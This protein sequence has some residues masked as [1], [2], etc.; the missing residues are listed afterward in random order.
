MNAAASF[1]YFFVY[2]RFNTIKALF[3]VSS[4]F[5]VFVRLTINNEI[6]IVPHRTKMTVTTLPIMVLGKKSPNPTLI[7]VETEN[8]NESSKVLIIGGYFPSAKCL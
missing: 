2:N 3:S 7:I 6:I 8:Q 4:I 5:N 1:N